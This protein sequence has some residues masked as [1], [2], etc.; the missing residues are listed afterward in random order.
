MVELLASSFCY[1]NPFSYWLHTRQQ[2]VG[3]RM[4]EFLRLLVVVSGETK[5]VYRIHHF[6]VL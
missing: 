2:P 1:R 5:E 6:A 4:F 3:G